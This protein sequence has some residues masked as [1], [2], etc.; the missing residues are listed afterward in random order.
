MSKSRFT[1]IELLVVI[2]IIA[3]LAAIL[4]P[5]LQQARERAMAT[6]CLN[7]L[8]QMNN[9]GQMYMHANRDFWPNAGATDNTYIHALNRA[10]LVP[11]AAVKNTAA[12]FASCPK[13]AVPVA[14]YSQPQTYGTQYVHNN[15][16][17]CSNGGS[18]TFVRD[19]ELSRVGYY[20][21]VSGRIPGG[22]TVP[23]SRRVMIA[24][25]VRAGSAGSVVQNA[26]LYAFNYS[27]TET[28]GAYF[29]HSERINLVCFAGNAETVS[30]DQHWN[31]YFYPH[32]GS[33]DRV[34][35]MSTL[36]TRFFSANGELI[37]K[38]R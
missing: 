32:Y 13:T 7:N 9:A 22:V 34:S 15:T 33:G 36:P 16:N 4:M 19:D 23:L 21:D 37:N 29:A 11:E 3:I 20:Q 1:L 5:A 6:N 27:G 12:T 10:D 26:R 31:E 35:P 2:A 18:G 14:G 28:G 24:D 17:Q 8:K 30:L 25:C 38:T